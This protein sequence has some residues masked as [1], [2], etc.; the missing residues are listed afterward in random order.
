MKNTFL[1]VLLASVALSCSKEEDP[2]VVKG[3]VFI[4]EVLANGED[5]LELYNASAQA[6]NVGGYAV[7]DDGTATAKY[8]LPTGT[9]IPAKGFL[10]LYCDGMAN[11]LHTN[12]KLSSLGE[13]VYLENASG[14]LTDMVSFPGLGVH[15]SYGRYPDGSENFAI[16]GTPSPGSTNGTSQSPVFTAV[17]RLPLVPRP[18]NDVVVSV[19]LAKVEPSTS[20][21]LYYQIDG[22]SFTTLT[23][24]A[25]GGGIFEATIPRLNTTGKVTYYAEASHGP[26][27]TALYPAT[28]PQESLNYL[29]TNDVLPKLYINEF[30]AENISCCPDPASSLEHD[31]WIEIYNAGTQPVNLAGMYVSDT[32]LNPFKYKIPDG[33]AAQTT[34]PAGGYL[35]IWADEQGT[36]GPLHANFKLSALGEDLG[37]YYIDGRTIDEL[38]FGAQTADVSRGRTPNGGTSWAN[39]SSPSPGASNQ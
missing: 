28:A 25:K 21:K 6:I 13:T 20:V 7:Y 29:M 33:A 26:A 36:Q 5:W 19:T 9:S 22:G 38:S 14:T 1:A 30:L 39:F 16:T 15:Q 24:A 31:D 35:V 18:E 2:T 32:K 3:E 23:M 37:L 4:N 17:S 12:F 10:L 27:R 11:G 8:I 34:I